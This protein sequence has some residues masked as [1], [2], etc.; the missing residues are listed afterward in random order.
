[1]YVEHGLLSNY[2]PHLGY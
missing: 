2:D 1:M